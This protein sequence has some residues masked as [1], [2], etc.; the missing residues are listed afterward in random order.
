MFFYKP[1]FFYST[2]DASSHCWS[3][4]ECIFGEVSLQVSR[5]RQH[6]HIINT[7]ALHWHV[8]ITGRRNPC[9]PSSTSLQFF[10]STL[11]PWRYNPT[12]TIMSSHLLQDI[13]RLPQSL[14]ACVADKVLDGLLS[15]RPQ[16]CLHF[17][18]LTSQHVGCEKGLLSTTHLHLQRRA[19]WE[20][21]AWTESAIPEV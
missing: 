21:S 8:W 11:R 7:C 9:T 18:T 20:C 14:L 13:I 15:F 5:G 12:T 6:G 19:L 10:K 4:Y 1:N 16:W 2:K 3:R 17:S